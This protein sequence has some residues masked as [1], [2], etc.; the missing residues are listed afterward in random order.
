MSNRHTIYTVRQSPSVIHSTY[1]TTRIRTV[2]D[3]RRPYPRNKEI[4]IM[5]YLAVLSS[6][7]VAPGFRNA[8]RVPRKVQTR[9]I[10]N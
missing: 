3:Y 2:G 9:V 4:E 8:Y 7:A 10:Q 5:I 1:L 6:E